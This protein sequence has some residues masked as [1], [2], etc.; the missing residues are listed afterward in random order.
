MLLDCK[1]QSNTSSLILH[2]GVLN[3]FPNIICLGDITECTP[4]YLLNELVSTVV[5][6]VI[7]IVSLHGYFVNGVSHCIAISLSFTNLIIFLA[8]GTYES[9]AHVIKSVCSSLLIQSVMCLNTSAPKAV[10]I[11]NPFV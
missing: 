6:F 4:D 1:S 9:A 10:T 2:N 11:L 3:F 7:Y 8:L 5:C